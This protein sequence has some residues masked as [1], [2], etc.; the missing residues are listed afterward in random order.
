MQRQTYYNKPSIRENGHLSSSWIHQKFYGPKQ[1]S[2]GRPTFI[3][4]TK[5]GNLRIMYQE[6]ENRFADIRA[7]LETL[8]G[9]GGTL[10]HASMCVDKDESAGIS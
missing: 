7:E 8:S 5:A 1:P 4:V 3:T 10:T 6:N 9:L 2:P